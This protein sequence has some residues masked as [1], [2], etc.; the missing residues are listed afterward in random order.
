[1]PAIL[2]TLGKCV[3]KIINVSSKYRNTPSS[4]IVNNKLI[5]EPVEVANKFNE[6][7]STIAENL[8]AKIYDTGTDFHQYL[9]DRNEHSIF[10]QPTNPVRIDKNN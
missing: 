7:F 2:K 4:L 5:S 10:I 8:Q 9:K 1:M 6:Y 3:N